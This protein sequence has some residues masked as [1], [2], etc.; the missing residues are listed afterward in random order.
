MLTRFFI[1]PPAYDGTSPV[2]HLMQLRICT[3]WIRCEGL[4]W[5]FMISPLPDLWEPLTHHLGHTRISE[6]SWPNGYTYALFAC[7]WRETPLSVWFERTQPGA[8]TTG[9]APAVQAPPAALTRADFTAAVRAA[10]RDWHSEDEFAA[11]PLRQ[12]TMLTS[13]PGYS[14]ERAADM[15]RDVL[16]DVIDD[17]RSEPR[18]AKLHRVIATTCFHR[19][20][21]QM[22]AAERLGLP[23][24]TYR[25]HLRRA[26]EQL[27]DAL[28][29]RENAGPQAA[30]PLHEVR[31]G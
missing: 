30:P 22:A 10:L 31:A 14:A 1:C 5:S 3:D 8:L 27:E 19:V 18:A 24:S 21:T 26:H 12:T 4:A 6:L 28:W 25:R 17:M 23:C 7:D 2:Q 20:P 13:R 16:T 9:A 15:L 29:R 11:D